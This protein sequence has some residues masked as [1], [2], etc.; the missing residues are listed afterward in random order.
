LLKLELSLFSDWLCDKGDYSFDV[1][2]IDDEFINTYL[3]ERAEFAK[4]QKE[5]YSY[6]YADIVP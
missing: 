4:K 5:R 1:T 2:K 3:S 6:L